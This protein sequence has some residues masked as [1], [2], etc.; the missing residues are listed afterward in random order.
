MKTYK[1][2]PFTFDRVVRLL[3]TIGFAIGSLWLINYL[4]GVLIP[5]V[6]A[7]LL[8]YIIHPLVDFFQY[9]TKFPRGLAISASFLTIIGS[10]TLLSWVF[11]PMINKEFISMG[12]I[13]ALYF[14]D[15]D[16]QQ[17]IPENLTDEVQKWASQEEVQ[18]ILN[19]ADYSAIV[20]KIYPK[21]SEVFT[22]SVDL[23]VSLLSMVII[24]LY[25]IFILV[26]YEKVMKGWK[27]LIPPHYRERVVDLVQDF[28]VGM[29]QYFRA[30]ALVA[31]IVGVLFAVGF[32]IIGLPLG[33]ILGLFIGALN[34]VPYLQTFG[35]I[36]AALLGTLHAIEYDR[37]VWVVLG[38]VGLVFVV[39]QLFQEAVLVP[40]IMGK[41]TG[42]SPVII[43][44]S[45]S[46][47]GALL[48]MLGL[49]IALPVT[50][51]IQAYY[52]RYIRKAE[53]LER[54]QAANS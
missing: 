26:D 4:S 6:I 8:A 25:L 31:T 13:L 41:V 43:I 9:K 12:E 33:I 21:L 51:L 11:I 18:S 52:L 5:F 40:K 35:L 3:I 28:N 16:A 42:L 32:E 27:K 49:L 20:K 46:I 19:K 7:L 50:T 48:G 54:K 10:I 39:V 14:K 30:Q 29:N 37:N 22:G 24:L 44:L 53:I 45:L 2:Q 38:L 17:Y 34:M 15:A 1:S 47:W 23:L 36:P